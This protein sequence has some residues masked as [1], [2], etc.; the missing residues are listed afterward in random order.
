MLVLFGHHR[1]PLYNFYI[2]TVQ[3]FNWYTDY[4]PMRGTSIVEK[5]KVYSDSL[6]K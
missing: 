6:E 2:Y 4:V 3:K 5:Q 1:A